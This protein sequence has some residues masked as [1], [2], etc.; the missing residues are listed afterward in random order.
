MGTVYVSPHPCEGCGETTRNPKFCSRSCGIRTN[1]SKHPKRKLSGEDAICIVCSS[2]YRR[3]YSNK[4]PTCSRKC[5]YQ[6]RRVSS[7]TPETLFVCDKGVLRTTVRRL[8]IRWGI[9]KLQCENCG[10]VEWQ[11]KPAP[12]QLDHINGVNYDHRLENIQMLC[13]NCHA[14]TDTHNGKNTAKAKENRRNS[15]GPLG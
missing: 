11:G 9:L 10:I 7:Y 2:T 5:L 3:N 15:Q 1:N 8:G 4:G 13:A 6:T 12:I 14:Q